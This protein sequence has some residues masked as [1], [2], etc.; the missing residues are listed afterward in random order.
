MA[1]KAAFSSEDVE[2]AK[3]GQPAISL[4]GYAAERGLQHIDHNTLAGYRTAL[5]CD[6]QFQFNVMRGRLPGGEHGILAHEALAL[7]WI[8]GEIAWSG[9]FQTIGK[10][11][12]SGPRLRDFAVGLIPFAEWFTGWGGGQE[13][14]EPARAPCTVAAVRVP[15]SAGAQPHLRIDNRDAAPPYDFGNDAELGPFGLAGWLLH[16][17]PQPDAEL[18]GELLVD[19]VGATLEAHSGDA[20]LQVLL[21]F[22]TLVVRRNGYLAD[23]AELDELCVLA[24]ALAR[25]VRAACRSRLPRRRFDEPLPAPAWETGAALPR[26]F[27]LEP[28]WQEWARSAAGRYR[29]ALEGT[30]AYHRAFPAVPVPG[31][32]KVVMR[33]TLPVLG[34][35]GRLVVHTEPGAARAAVVVLAPSGV[36]S[37]SPDGDRSDTDPAVRMEVRD[38]LAGIYTVSS[39]WG[40]AMAGDVDALLA[41]AAEVLRRGPV[42]TG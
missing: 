4:S 28:H 32:A 42:A 15:E 23:P 25:N 19:P 7:P 33:G 12:R 37:A 18:V 39:Y 24:G 2:D 5:P 13:D 8:D 38:G 21:T 22:A 27:A 31:F 34:V 11:K 3:R 9:W 1:Y 20:L 35:A 36:T 16:A 10:P 14:V 26:G 17:D 40:S 41:A 29:L 6:P 30:V